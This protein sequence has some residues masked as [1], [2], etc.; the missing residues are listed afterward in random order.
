M[1]SDPSNKRNLMC[2]D[3][4]DLKTKKGEWM[5]VPVTDVQTRLY[6]WMTTPEIPA[7]N[8]A[9]KEGYILIGSLPSIDAAKSEVEQRKAQEAKECAFRKEHPVEYVK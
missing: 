5:M 8:E 6:Q 1:R 2:E 9:A 4:I 3:D 7:L